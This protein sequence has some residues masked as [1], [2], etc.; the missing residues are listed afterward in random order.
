MQGGTPTEKVTAALAEWSS[1][2]LDPIY[3]VIFVDAIVVKVRDGQVRNTPFY[4]VTA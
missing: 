3:P 1:L 2:P 4:V